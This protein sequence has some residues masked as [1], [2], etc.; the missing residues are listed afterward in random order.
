M[1]RIDRSTV[2]PPAQW[3]ARAERATEML[4]KV[5]RRGEFRYDAALMRA[6]ELRE[7][8]GLLFH[9]KCAYCETSVDI[10]A[11]PDT[12][13]FRPRTTAVDL[14]G[15]TT[16]PG[17]WWL[18]YAW[19]NVYVA[20]Q[21]CNRNK[22]NR[23]PVSGPRART[24]DDDL[25]AE[26]PLLLDPC[27]DAPDEHLLFDAAGAVASRSDA[28]PDRGAFTIDC[29]GLNRTS[30][31]EARRLAAEALS[32][33]FDLMVAKGLDRAEVRRRPNRTISKLV[34]A[35]RPYVALQRQV[36]SDLVRGWA[37]AD[38]E[39]VKDARVYK[40][41]LL[42][43]QA[44]HEED[45]RRASIE[46]N[47]DL[48]SR[49]SQR[50]ERVELENFR[51]IRKLGFDLGGGSAEAAG[52]T[53][54]LGENGVGKSSVLQALAIAL[55]GDD[56]VGKLG[57]DAKPSEILRRG[58]TRGAI[59]IFFSA[60]P[61]PLEVH[62]SP[63]RIDFGEAAKRPRMIVL[64]FG[65]SRWLPRR[66]GFQPDRS[67]WVRVQNLF[68]PFVPLADT[69][70]W[71]GT[72][73]DPEYERTEAA[74]LRLLRL[75]EGQHLIRRDGDILV[76][77]RRQRAD[78]AIP[79][80]HYSD[81]Y[82]AVVAMVGDIMELLSPKKLDMAVAEGLVLVDEL[83]AHLHPT[84]KLQVVTRLRSVFPGLQFVTTTHDP[85]CLRGL[86]DDE[87]LLL[88]RNSRGEIVGTSELPSL[89]ALRVDQ[90]LTSPYF[91]LHST[92]EPEVDR[93]FAEY[94]RLLPKKEKL[95]ARE[96]D[97][98]DELRATLDTQQ[99]LGSDRR[100]QLMLEAIDEHLAREATDLADRKDERIDER[101]A[102][103]LAEILDEPAP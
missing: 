55:M 7:A 75:D 52:W 77:A 83:E 93:Q 61:E 86:H 43:Y 33:E 56:R 98:F 64:G 65:S 103:K 87:V 74:L 85:L 101:T 102:A 81:G 13:H 76:R 8:L 100:E 92:R 82:Q 60:D 6:P 66:G 80:R 79:L 17:Y 48:E 12:A 21:Q 25:S 59:R 28:D 24:P 89:E 40:Q 71:L 16:K 35:G 68:N 50:I 97:R 42:L 72:L 9:G 22:G 30:L 73:L 31:V 11:K 44:A 96:Q 5:V 57:A 3:Q 62:L 49:Q 51:G 91:G 46:D 37:L 70:R 23:F 95:S 18:A 78:R 10:A 4:A 88:R 34:H 47:P 36:A 84:W 63:T 90:L 39:Q 54:L 26:R 41:N 2:T 32:T 15:T 27:A 19:S 38:T 20:C 45:L 29:L 53:M 58:S 67:D 99:L 14:D 94:Y 69:L 1:I